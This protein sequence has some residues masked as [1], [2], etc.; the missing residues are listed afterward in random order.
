MSYLEEDILKK[1]EK[2]KKKTCNNIEEGYYINNRT[3]HFTKES[4]LN[5][6]T[7]YLPDTFRLMPL[8]L[9]Q[10]KYP[11]EF[12]PQVIVTSLDLNIN[13]GFSVFSH[14]IHKGQ[15]KELAMRIQSLIE[16]E[17]QSV[18]YVFE[19][20]EKRFGYYFT[21]RSHAMDSDIYN[22][23]LIS[24]LKETMLQASFNCPYRQY[25]DWK[26]LVLLIWETIE[27]IE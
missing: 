22:M 1:R 6:F 9:A 13:F 2:I 26:N 27:E 17:K 11:S 19:K 20:L 3:L 10:V 8:E 24:P 12:R 4:L 25:K 5:K 18:F 7:V 14:E 16:S 21:F 15:T 23:Q